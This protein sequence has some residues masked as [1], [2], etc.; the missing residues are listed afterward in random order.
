MDQIRQAQVNPDEA[1]RE[2]T[3]ISAH[4]AR[5]DIRSL[6]EWELVLVGG[7]DGSPNWP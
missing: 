4:Q 2:A 1:T 5:N 3:E 7:G 6:D